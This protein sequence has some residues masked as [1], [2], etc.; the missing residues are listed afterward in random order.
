MFMKVL[1]RNDIVRESSKISGV[2]LKQT[3]E[4]INAMLEVI[5]NELKEGNECKFIGYFNLKVKDRK[6]KTGR[7][8]ITG[9]TI[10]IP[11]CKVVSAKV[12]SVLKKAVN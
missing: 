5:S 3:K 7:N 2:S 6:A 9:K 1:N 8:P 11:A 12:G 10:K 4:V